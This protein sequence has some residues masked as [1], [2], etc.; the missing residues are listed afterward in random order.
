[1][2]EPILSRP[3]W[4]RSAVW[5][6]QSKAKAEKTWRQRQAEAMEILLDSENDSDDGDDER[7]DSF[8]HT[9]KQKDALKAALATLK[10]E[11]KKPLLPDGSGIKSKFLG[12]AR[13]L[14]TFISRVAARGRVC[15]QARG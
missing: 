2:G 15:K 1:M 12:E 6:T 14:L 4:R 3:V 7:S 5:C 10:E 8:H 13:A 11:L 9:Q